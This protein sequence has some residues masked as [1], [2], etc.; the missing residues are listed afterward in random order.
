MQRLDAQNDIENV[1]KQTLQIEM[2]KRDETWKKSNLQIIFPHF[3]F[4]PIMQVI[5]DLKFVWNGVS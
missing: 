2:K 5:V 4:E 1:S 3:L